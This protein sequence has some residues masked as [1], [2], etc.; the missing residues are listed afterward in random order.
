MHVIY[1]KENVRRT[2]GLR[3]A[4]GTASL[5]KRSGTTVWIDLYACKFTGD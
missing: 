3:D 2:P 1:V 5:L 4:T